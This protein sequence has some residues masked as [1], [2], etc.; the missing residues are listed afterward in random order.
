MLSEITWLRY[1]LLLSLSRSMI[2]HLNYS[3]FSKLDSSE[4]F[5]S[6]HCLLAHTKPLPASPWLL[7]EL[8]LCVS[9]RCGKS[10]G[11]S[12]KSFAFLIK[13]TDNTGTIPPLL[14][15]FL[16]QMKMWSKAQ[17]YRKTGFITFIELL[18]QC[19]QP[20]AFR[21]HYVRKIDSSF[22]RPSSFS[23]LCKLNLS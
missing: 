16:G 22:F 10:A 4:S 21:V 8:P 15:I 1:Y 9:A 2:Y 20:Y 18:N 14:S 17:C 7:G 23:N 3:F 6:R 12:R 11:T 5:K 19:P 13:G